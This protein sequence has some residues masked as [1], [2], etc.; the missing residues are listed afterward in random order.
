MSFYKTTNRS[1]GSD[2]WVPWTG[3]IACLSQSPADQVM[4]P[5]LTS[6]LLLF[7]SAVPQDWLQRLFLVCWMRRREAPL[8][9]S[10]WVG[11][12]PWWALCGWQMFQLRGC[13]CSL[14][15]PQKR[16]CQ[17]PQPLHVHQGDSLQNTDLAFTSSV[18]EGRENFKLGSKPQ[19]G[20]F[21]ASAHCLSLSLRACQSTLQLYIGLIIE[22][23]RVRCLQKAR[24]SAAGQQLLSAGLLC[25]ENWLFNSTKK[26]LTGS[27]W[28][29]GSACLS[30]QW[31]TSRWYLQS[32]PIQ[33]LSPQ[34]IRCTA[35][36]GTSS[37]K[38]QNQSQLL[39]CSWVSGAWDSGLW[40]PHCISLALYLWLN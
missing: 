8:L 36:V 14:W 25:F 23:K 34:I 35:E 32:E 33:L 21:A 11:L 2:F 39:G 9:C 13:T 24:A 10:C 4:T 37:S 1:S 27:I 20:G 6:A 3:I 38:T 40:G 22:G 30:S 28:K 17:I 19:F 16:C 15:Q 5:S 29:A 7:V 26:L 18:S 31:E 12:S